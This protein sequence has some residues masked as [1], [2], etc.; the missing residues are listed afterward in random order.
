[1][2]LIAKIGSGIAIAVLGAL[3]MYAFRVRQLYLLVP[4][5]FGYS[6]LTEKGK[7]LELRVFNRGRS[8][9]EDVHIDMPPALTYELIAADH[10][11]VQLD[12]NKLVL[13]RI[14]PRSE[15]SLVVLAE[16]AIEAE[17]FSPTLSSKTTKGKVVKKLEEV[18]PNAGVVVL[19]IGGVLMLFALVILIPSKWIEY[20]N[21]RQETQKKEILGR[22]AFLEQSGWR[23][24]DS[25]V[26]SEVRRSY[27]G[28]E[29]PIAFNSARRKGNYVEIQFLATNKTAAPLKATAYFDTEQDGVSIVG[30]KSVFDMLVNPMQSIPVVVG[31]Q[32][33]RNHPLEKLFVKLNLKFGEEN[34]WGVRFYPSL[35]KTAN[36]ALQGT[37]ASGRP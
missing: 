5:M 23:K 13:S 4:K 18:P 6:A 26:F 2:D 10:P 16:G 17:S 22:Y 35:N 29:F 36:Q 33:S 3:V 31:T 8:M 27:S 30:E 11:D 21:E 34:V 14:P 1:M 20:Q 15:V 19:S 37:P 24:F 32:I 28:F 7:I 9:E 25:Y 12:K